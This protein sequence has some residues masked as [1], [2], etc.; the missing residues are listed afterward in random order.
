MHIGSKVIE[1]VR[2]NDLRDPSDQ[3]VAVCDQK[4]KD[5]FEVDR[6]NLFEMRDA[7]TKHL[8]PLDEAAI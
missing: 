7:W 6:L 1:Y 4:M 3:N 2:D 8:S 5:V